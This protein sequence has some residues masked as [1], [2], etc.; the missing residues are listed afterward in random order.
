[1]RIKG[2]EDLR[3]LPIFAAAGAFGFSA[4]AAGGTGI[5]GGTASFGAAGTA[6]F[7]GGVRFG[8]FGNCP[9]GAEGGGA[10]FG[11]AGGAFTDFAPPA[12]SGSLISGRAPFGAPDEAESAFCPDGKGA[13]PAV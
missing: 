1:M 5:L 13:L 12:T 2:R 8:A 6:G 4:D 10:S 7:S 9:S 11:A 3:G